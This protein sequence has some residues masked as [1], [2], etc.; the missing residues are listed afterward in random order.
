MPPR[1][2]DTQR[3]LLLLDGHE[4]R[5]PIG[6]DYPLSVLRRTLHRHEVTGTARFLTFCCHRRLRLFDNPRVRDRFVE[7]LA[8][9]AAS[10]AANVM[11]WVVMPEHVHLVIFSDE[12]ALT[13]TRFTHALKRQFAVE[14]LY[15]WK[16]LNA[17]ILP[18]LT[19]GD[20]YRF[21][22]TGGGYDRNVIGR[23]LLEKIRYI[24]ANPVRRGLVASP[25]DYRWSSAPAYTGHP[26]AGPPIRF[27]LLPP[28][29]FPLV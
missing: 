27:D 8:A 23:E 5:H 15:R 22:Q 7:H 19:K 18:S 12:P 3:Q 13:M 20:G 28:S 10:R 17:P 25:V 6:H 1:Q 21:W 24:H 26:H 14:V 16:S 2:V 9:T 11:A 4:A 29:P